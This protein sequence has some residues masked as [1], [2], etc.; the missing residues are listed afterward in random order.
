MPGLVRHRQPK[1]AGTDRPAL[2]PWHQCSTLPFAR[3]T[4]WNSMISDSDSRPHATNNVRARL[5]AIKALRCACPRL[6][7]SQPADRRPDVPG[8]LRREG[9]QRYLDMIAR[10]RK[11]GLPTPEF[12]KSEG[13]FIQALRRPSPV[14]TAEVTGEVTAEVAP[15]ATPQ[16]ALEVRVVH[17]LAGEIKRYRTVCRGYAGTCR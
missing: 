16:V 10:C 6:H 15:Q 7:P 17:V 14:P 8:A 1:G 4:P 11:A 5:M 12:C 13:Q 2:T 9:G 3:A